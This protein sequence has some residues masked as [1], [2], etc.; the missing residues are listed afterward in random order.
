MKLLSLRVEIIIDRG[1]SSSFFPSPSP[2]TCEQL[3]KREHWGL[4]MFGRDGAFFME[5]EGEGERGRERERREER[6]GDCRRERRK[7]EVKQPY[8]R[9]PPISP[10][11]QHL[12]DGVFFRQVNAVPPRLSSSRFVVAKKREVFFRRNWATVTQSNQQQHL[13]TTYI[14]QKR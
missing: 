2:Q 1:P 6:V 13:C 10:S 5:R 14:L 8:A 7:K 11:G 3:S 9:V 12:S 4:G